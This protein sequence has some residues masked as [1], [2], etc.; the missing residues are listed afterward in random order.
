MKRILSGEFISE[1]QLT[2]TSH[3]G[4][5]DSYGNKEYMAYT[6]KGFV[7]LS[8]KAGHF[9]CNLYFTI[10]PSSHT[11]PEAYNKLKPYYKEAYVFSTR[12]ELYKW[13]SED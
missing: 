5:V 8:T 12:K 2:Q 1:D 4:F 9:T 3:I 6:E 11:L 13:L 10:H 7:V